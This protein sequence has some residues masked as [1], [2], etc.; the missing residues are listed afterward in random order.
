MNF[1][2]ESVDFVMDFCVNF[3]C[4]FLGAFFPI[5]RRTDNPLRNPRQNSRQNPCKIHAG[6]EKRRRKIHSAGRGAQKKGAKSA[7]RT[8]RDDNKHKIYVYEGGGTL[9]AERGIVQKW[10]FYSGKVNFCTGT[11]KT[12]RGATEPSQL[13][14]PL[15]TRPPRNPSPRT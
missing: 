7:N 10:C 3:I 12:F 11:V 15:W 8:R 2:F 4:G 5:K 1:H 9:G 6:G 14:L 13:D